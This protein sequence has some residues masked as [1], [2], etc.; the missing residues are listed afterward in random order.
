[1][2]DGITVYDCEMQTTDSPELPKRSRYYQGQIDAN[3]IEKGESYRKLKKSLVIF[4]CTFD[5]FGKGR[6]V[7]SFENICRE[8]CSV[9][10]K[11]EAE[12]IFVNTRGTV[13]DVS[14]E[15]KELMDYFNDPET[16]EKSSNNLVKDID[17]AVDA[18]RSN[19]D[20]RHD[21]MTWQM[22]GNE[23]FEQGMIKGKAEGKAEGLAEGKAKGILNTLWGLLNGGVISLSDA[24]KQ[25]G[26]SEEA[27][28][29]TKPV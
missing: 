13:G 16:A 5:P 22:Y 10:L 11:D 1:M 17:A 4:I 25:A 2:E 20:W 12:K 18:A 15:F 3:L 29:K 9:F 23:Q 19:D 27:F 26:M 28:L 6:Y 8:D 24:A 21:Y 7:Y 14:K